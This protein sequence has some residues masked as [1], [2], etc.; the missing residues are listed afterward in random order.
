MNRRSVVKFAVAASLIPT[1]ALA[2]SS[3]SAPS[4]EAKHAAE[5]LR[6]GALALESSRIALNKA[7]D[8]G[9]KRFA[10]FEAAEQETVAMVVKAASKLDAAA[11]APDKEGKAILESLNGIG[12]GK[13]FDVAY[14]KVQIDGHQRLLQIQDAYLASGRDVVHRS[15][16][17]LARGHIQEHLSTLEM[18]QRQLS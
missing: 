2:Q 10:E 14:I 15:I 18:L 7:S 16:A 8:T 6:A 17:A 3:Q 13:S 4:G 1:A 12:G 11:A 5:T 9:V